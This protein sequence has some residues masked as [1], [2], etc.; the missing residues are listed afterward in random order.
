M[1][2]FLVSS[3]FVRLHGFESSSR[4]TLSSYVC[5]LCNVIMILSL[6]VSC[7]D[8]LASCLHNV[9]YIIHIDLCSSAPLYTSSGRAILGEDVMDS[10]DF[11]LVSC[12]WGNLSIDSGANSD[13]RCDAGCALG[14][15]S[16]V[17]IMDGLHHSRPGPL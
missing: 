11:A 15:Y 7:I 12:S 8:C 14:M 2:T 10:L 5:T 9:T 13:I 16:G 1:W 4:C 6:S 3:F 17:A